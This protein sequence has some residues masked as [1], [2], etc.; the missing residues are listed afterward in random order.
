MMLPV[1]VSP[2]PP[3]H[4]CI[5]NHVTISLLRDVH[6]CWSM[7]LDM[8]H[9]TVTP[10]P[11]PPPPLACN[12]LLG[13]SSPPVRAGTHSPSIMSTHP[14]V[15]HSLSQSHTNTPDIYTTSMAV[16]QVLMHFSDWVHVYYSKDRKH[17]L[18][19][20]LQGKKEYILVL[21]LTP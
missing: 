9:L 18:C 13:V 3:L 14:T 17:S 12:L 10:L 8:L 5:F 20:Q 4:E 15:T 7:C 2:P 21:M 11:Q 6:C 1:V 19:S 16:F